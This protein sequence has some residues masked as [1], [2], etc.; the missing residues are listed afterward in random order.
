MAT[1]I[2]PFSAFPA[3]QNKVY[4]DA[5]GGS[6]NG[7]IVEGLGVMASLDA[8]AEMHLWFRTPDPLP[9]G[10]CKL[11]LNAVSYD[12]AAGDAK[13]NPYWK[14]IAVDEVFDLDTTGL[15]AEGTAT[16]TWSN[17]GTDSE[18]LQSLITL[19]AD[20]PVAGEFIFIILLFETSSWTL[21]KRSV[22][23][24]SIIWE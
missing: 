13:V 2:F 6:T 5:F 18:I 9:T 15:N 7:A 8:N 10:T 17:P 23:V 3:T 19:D 24:P 22:W 20:T 21:N 16:L 1:R 11:E 12:A 4:P 14:S